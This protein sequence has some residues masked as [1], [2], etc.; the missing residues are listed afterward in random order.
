MG[1]GVSSGFARRTI[2]PQRLWGIDCSRRPEL[3]AIATYREHA[4]HI[5]DSHVEISQIPLLDTTFDNAFGRIW[6]F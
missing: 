6:S 3:R 4:Q 5:S 2:D 1:D